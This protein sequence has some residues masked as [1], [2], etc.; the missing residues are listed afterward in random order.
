MALGARVYEDHCADCHGQAGEGRPGEAPRLAGNRGVTLASPVNVVRMVLGGGF[1]P[2][3]AGHPR[4]FGMPP[5]ATRLSD[6]E[7]AAVVTYLRTSWGHRASPVNA[8][9]VNRL[10]GG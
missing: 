9:E 3:T 4:P 2:A 5:Y 7:I 8:L 6:A 10:R 1:G